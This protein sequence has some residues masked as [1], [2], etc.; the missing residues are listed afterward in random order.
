MGIMKAAVLGGLLILLLTV[1]LSSGLGLAGYNVPVTEQW[2]DIII[3]LLCGV[4]AGYISP[5]R[6]S[7]DAIAGLGAGAIAG[8]CSIFLRLIIINAI[9]STPFDM[10]QVTYL[11]PDI[12]IKTVAL[13]VFAAVGA[14]IGGLII[15]QPDRKLPK[16]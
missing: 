8:F 9:Y 15:P 16:C 4:L 3:A 1:V 14:I 12:L 11:L 2:W 7:Q 13:G 6:L 5:G 10:S